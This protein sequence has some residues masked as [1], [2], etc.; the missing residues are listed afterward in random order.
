MFFMF[1]SFSVCNLIEVYIWMVVGLGCLHSKAHKQPNI[2]SPQ[3]C[4][5]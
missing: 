4:K 3:D 5:Q 2:T 1:M